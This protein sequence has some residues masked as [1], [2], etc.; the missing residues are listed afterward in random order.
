MNIKNIQQNTLLNEL[1]SLYKNQTK[2]YA[3]AVVAKSTT[4]PGNSNDL[5]L[6]NSTPKACFFIR[7]TRTPKE[8]LE[9]LSM[10]ACNGKGFALCCV[11]S[12]A[13]FQPVTRYRPNPGKFS[14]SL[15]KSY[16]ELSK[17]FYTFLFIHSRLRISVFANSLT[18]A[19]SRLP[20]SD[21]KPLLIARKSSRVKGGLYA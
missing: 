12:I 15:H 19:Y 18:E 13:V 17:M 7:S 10:V 1:F 8:R 21:V 20:K 11:P 3:L 4:E 2:I 5:Y 14:G 6:A 16:L 9:R